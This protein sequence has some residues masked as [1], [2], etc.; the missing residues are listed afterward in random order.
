MSEQ[1]KIYGTNHFYSTDIYHE[2]DCTDKEA[3]SEVIRVS[4]G[5]M[6]NMLSNDAQAVWVI[7]SWTLKEETLDILSDEH[8]MVLDLY[9]DTDPKWKK[10]NAFKGKPWI[11]CI[12]QNFGGRTGM[13]GK[14]KLMA[15]EIPRV[16]SS[17]SKGKLSGIGLAPEGIGGNPIFLSMLSE[18][19]WRKT[20]PDFSMWLRTF[21][22][23]RYA[24]QLEAADKAWEILLETVYTG[25]EAYGPL[26]S[27]ICA[28][29]SLDIKKVSSNGGTAL[30]Y[31]PELLVE[32]WKL[33]LDCSEALSQSDNFKYDLV[34]VSRQVMSNYAKPVYK[35]IVDAYRNKKTEELIVY[36]EEF[37]TIMEDM[38][39]L[40][41]TNKE[42]LLGK[43]L[44]DAKK[45]GENSIEKY[46]IEWNARRQITLWSSPEI[47]EFHDYANKQ[48][49]GLI[50][51]Y[52]LPRWKKFLQELQTSLAGN[53]EIDFD[54][55]RRKI[56]LWAVK[57]SHMKN[58]YSSEPQGSEILI[59]KYMFEKYKDKLASEY[60]MK[61]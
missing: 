45:I 6:K 15:E 48:W 52:Y 16:L 60:G 9:C 24:K 61:K 22:R 51:S 34:D 55:F 23:S 43:W 40:L 59:S 7:Q 14:I 35:K 57:W 20:Q 13:S 32:A 18:M 5:V 44:N 54:K 39:K 17:E 33:L 56:N 19:T 58:S 29:P 10:N 38:D 21:V 25:P 11:W 2:I 31:K 3:L 36:S 8:A 47:D 4:D 46:S 30:Y 37:I 42:F 49:A 41:S 1:K 53:K 26:E 50:K 12:L 27:E 28:I